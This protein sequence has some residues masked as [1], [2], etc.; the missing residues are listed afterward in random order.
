LNNNNHSIEVKN[1]TKKFGKFTSVDR[2]SFYVNEGEVFGFLGANGAGKSTTIRM[3]CGILEP[4]SGDAMVGGYSIK[5]QPDM[6]KRHI[7]YMSQ[8]FSL[9]NDLTV[10]ENIKFFGSVYGLFGKKMEARKNWVLKIA[11]LEGK[12][13]VLAHNLAIG[14][15]QRLALGCAVIHEPRIVF[16]DE[17]TGGVDPISRRGFWELINDLSQNGITVFVTT[18]YLD[19]A[20]YCNRIMMIDAGKIIAGGSPKEIKTNYLKS[21]IL[22]IEC[23]RV[24]EA[25][26]ILDKIEWIRN[27]AY[28]GK[29]LHA[30]IPA[31]E[32]ENGLPDDKMVRI[33]EILEEENGMNVIRIDKI[34]P[35]LEDVFVNL[36]EGADK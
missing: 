5:K 21:I 13:K 31:G 6:I 23:D 32:D 33:R 8:K 29:F 1:L 4:T 30:T 28:F 27:A 36:L 34:I 18:H 11:K 14:F 9:Y 25:I 2:I 10:E 12:E 35:S 3:L 26:T 7:G 17:P 15:K 20:E 16:L 24:D 19:E 22:E